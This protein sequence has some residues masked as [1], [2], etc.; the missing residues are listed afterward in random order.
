VPF[1]EYCMVPSMDSITSSFGFRYSDQ[2]M[3]TS[4]FTNLLPQSGQ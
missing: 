3:R 2:F 1:P 4:Y